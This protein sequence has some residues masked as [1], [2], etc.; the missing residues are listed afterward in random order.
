MRK[1]D[2]KKS[3]IIKHV[4]VEITMDNHKRLEGLAYLISY[5]CNLHILVVNFNDTGG[6][7][8]SLVLKVDTTHFFV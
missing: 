1:N 6:I 8:S 7:Y 5:Y 4:Q 2:I 3:S